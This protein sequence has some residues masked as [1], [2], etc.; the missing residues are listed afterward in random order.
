MFVRSW[1]LTNLSYATLHWTALPQRF[2]YFS[3]QY[4]NCVFYWISC[5]SCVW[6]WSLSGDYWLLSALPVYIG[7][8]S[9]ESSRVLRAIFC[10]EQN[11][12]SHLLTHKEKIWS[13]LLSFDGWFYL[14]SFFLSLSQS[15]VS[16]F[17]FNLYGFFLCKLWMVHAIYSPFDWMWIYPLLVMH[18]H[19][20]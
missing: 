3:Y 9:S 14:W 4:F 17:E 12:S 19:L 2:S 1:T 11:K 13:E 10:Q 18:I 7:L 15:L 6:T 20:P 5:V 16:W 8:L